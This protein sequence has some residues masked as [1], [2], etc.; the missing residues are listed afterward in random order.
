[1]WRG[2]RGCRKRG[3]LAPPACSSLPERRAREKE[4]CGAPMAALEDV[5]RDDAL[6]RPEH[7]EAN[8]AVDV[9]DPRALQHLA[10]GE[11]LAL[12]QDPAEVVR[13]ED[14]AALVA[15]RIR[16]EPPFPARTVG[17]QGSMGK[18]VGPKVAH[19]QGWQQGARTLR[20]T[21]RPRTFAWPPRASWPG[22]RRSRRETARARR[23]CRR[24]PCA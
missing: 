11:H 18:R 21:R 9:D 24:R 6:P 10:A 23:A 16:G 3:A 2:G 8:G 13:R 4:G 5:E 15:A 7:A 17:G 19:R 12:A 22:A 20:P 1:M 14:S